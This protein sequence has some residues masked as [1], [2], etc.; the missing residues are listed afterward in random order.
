MGSMAN[1][2]AAV[3]ELIA[4]EV[5][6]IPKAVLFGENINNGSRISGLCRNLRAGR[7]SQIINVGNC[8][9]THCGIGFGLMLNGV[10]SVLFVKQLDFMLLGMDH[11]VNTYNFIR[12]HKD[13]SSLGSFTIIT[14][15]CDQGFQG[16][17]SSFNS[18]GD[19]CSLTRVPGY[20][21]TNSQDAAH[22][23]RRQLK[24][25]GF[26]F[27]CLSQRLFSTEFL[28]LELVYAAEDCSVFQYSDGDD[29]T[30]VCFNFSLPHGRALQEQFFA[31]GI[32][33]SLFSVNYVFPQCWDRIRTSVSR[34]RRLVV[35]DDSKS[36]NLF[37]QTMIRELSGQCPPFQS[38]VVARG[39]EIEFGVC[40]DNFQINHDAIFAQLGY[41]AR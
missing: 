2:I 34:S 28:N 12:C 7:G 5:E 20:T 25:P 35:I 17:Q 14:M 39:A 10:H 36:V 26:R 15:V 9:A 32:S 18:L 16:P 38:V 27:I 30:I 23:L 22:V 6:M 4:D 31:R 29:V 3:N 1:Y 41:E 24:N 21:I 11:F 8:E 40:P 33:A 13:P 19:I 37:G